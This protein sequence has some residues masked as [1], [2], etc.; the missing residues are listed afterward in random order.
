M[1]PS[2]RI[3]GLIHYTSRLLWKL[4]RRNKKNTLL[5]SNPD[6]LTTLNRHRRIPSFQRHPLQQIKRNRPKRLRH[7]LKNRFT[8]KPLSQLT[9]IQ[10]LP[11]PAIW[12]T[13]P[14]PT[15]INLTDVIKQT[16]VNQLPNNDV[17]ISILRRQAISVSLNQSQLM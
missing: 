17:R 5:T 14:R 7:Q 9:I 3:R 4:I 16:S 10:P 13:K 15:Q 6:H 11:A 2:F 1:A 8:R 12:I